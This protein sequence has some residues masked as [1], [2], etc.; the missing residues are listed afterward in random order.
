MKKILL[1]L[2][3]GTLLANC[4]VKKTDPK[5]ETE[6]EVVETVESVI[7]NLDNPRTGTLQI[8]NTNQELLLKQ[9]GDKCGEWGGD[10]EEFRIYR[11]S[12]KGKILVDY[13][14]TI[15]DCDDPYSEKNDPKIIEKNGFELTDTEL[16]LIDDCINELIHHKLSV[17][18]RI[19]HSGIAN[20]VIARDSSLVIVDYPSFKWPKFKELTKIIT[21]K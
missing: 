19:S 5:K 11:I 15:I 16:K 18:P 10:T 2:I 7:K 3:I 4:A 1:I 21:R 6:K 17:E 12:Y 20:Y 13:K 9:S 8:I 14:K